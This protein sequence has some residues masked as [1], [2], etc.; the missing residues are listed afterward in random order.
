MASYNDLPIVNCAEDVARVCKALE[1]E[2]DRWKFKAEVSADIC[3]AMEAERDDLRRVLDGERRLAD[4]RSSQL[5]A[6]EAER[7]RCL[8]AL[9]AIS[10]ARPTYLLPQDRPEDVHERACADLNEIVKTAITALNAQ[11]SQ[12]GDS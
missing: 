6:A 1:A 5:V 2:R 7:D 9:D 4:H 3:S 12:E 11:Q 8:E 10:R